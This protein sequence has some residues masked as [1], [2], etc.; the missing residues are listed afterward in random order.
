M[1][2]TS[3]ID[4]Y[5]SIDPIFFTSD[6]HFGHKNILDFC[7]RPYKTVSEMNVGLIDNWNSVVPENGMVFVLGDFCFGNATLWENCR[8]ALHGKICLIKGNH[9]KL[10]SNVTESKLFE[11][12]CIQKTIQID[13]RLVIMN[14]YP[15]LCYAGTYQNPKTATWQ[16]FGHLHLSKTGIGLDS[17]RTI[18]CFPTQ[19]DVGVDLNDYKPLTWQQVSDKIN[20]Q[21]K[22][23]TNVHYWIEN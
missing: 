2:R 16:L 3:K 8:N 21:I 22:N 14:H 18:N 12:V 20:F 15:F 1:S 6:L 5:K 17:K 23:N 9:D 4:Q 13:D 19:Y 11:E 7:N 10:A